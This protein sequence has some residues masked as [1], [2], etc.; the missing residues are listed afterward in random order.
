MSSLCITLHTKWND[1]ID[2][3]VEIIGYEYMS[4]KQKREAIK[5]H[6]FDNVRVEVELLNAKSYEPPRKEA[7]DP[8]DWWDGTNIYDFYD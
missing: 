3:Y 8:M 2:V 5:K 6:I 1:S 7:E 4:K